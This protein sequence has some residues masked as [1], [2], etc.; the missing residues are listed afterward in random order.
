MNRILSWLIFGIIIGAAYQYGGNEAVIIFL[1]LIIIA[2]S[3]F[4]KK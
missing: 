3:E 4:E 1:L 2:K